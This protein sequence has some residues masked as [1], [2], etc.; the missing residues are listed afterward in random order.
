MDMET[1]E[2]ALPLSLALAV[3]VFIAREALAALLDAAVHD[4]WVKLRKTLGQ[5]GSCPA[6][7]R[8]G[9]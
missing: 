9:R 2:L 7:E 4:A 8:N 1:L 5:R 6:R 3:V